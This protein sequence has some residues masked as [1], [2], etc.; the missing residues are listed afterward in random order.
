MHKTDI[1]KLLTDCQNWAT[2]FRSHLCQHML[3]N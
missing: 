3:Y 1:Y 2:T